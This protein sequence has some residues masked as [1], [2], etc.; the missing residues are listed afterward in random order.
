MDFGTRYWFSGYLG[1]PCLKTIHG[2]E[3]LKKRD[4]GAEFHDFLV[5]K[6]GKGDDQ[7]FSGPHPITFNTIG[8]VSL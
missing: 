1:S 5:Q 4:S 2:L 8:R 6:K 7:E 3:M